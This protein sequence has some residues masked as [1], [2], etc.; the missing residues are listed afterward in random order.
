MAIRGRKPKPG[1][2]KA[3]TGN[4]GRRAIAP[5]VPFAS[6][7]GVLAPPA[8][9]VAEGYERLEWNRIVPELVRCRI[10]KAIHQGALEGICER[11]AAATRLYQIG[12]FSGA[13]QESEAHR[14]ALNEFGLTPASAGRV[15]AV[16]GDGEKDPAESFFT[17]PVAVND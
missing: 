7:E 9:W 4:P 2:L 3:A 12:Q 8:H 15:G 13:R 11:Y 1:A 10:A 16:G 14:K 5:E 17:G 6:G